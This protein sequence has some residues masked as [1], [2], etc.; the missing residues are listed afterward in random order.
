MRGPR[1][2]R[3][4]R[5]REGGRGE[6]GEGGEWRPPLRMSD[7]EVVEDAEGVSCEIGGKSRHERNVKCMQ[8]FIGIE[9]LLQNSG[10]SIAV[11]DG[12]SHAVVVSPPRATA[13]Q[14]GIVKGL[15]GFEGKWAGM[16]LGGLVLE[17]QDIEVL[18]RDWLHEYFL[19]RDVTQNEV[20]LV[21]ARP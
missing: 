12:G 11:V 2:E 9:L 3:R 8:K 13:P 6:R 1:E 17:A 7:R 4:G 20:C 16:K 19:T 5:K 21:K 14:G 10:N 15:R 18:S